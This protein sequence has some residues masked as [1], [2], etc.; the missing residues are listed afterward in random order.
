MRGNIHIFQPTQVF[1]P[2]VKSPVEVSH[3]FHAS[4]MKG[5]EICTHVSTS[6][7]TC[8]HMF[9]GTLCD[10]SRKVAACHNMS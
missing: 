6:S 4:F 3:V 7:M 1:P 9:H 2:L 10:L 5:L 8:R